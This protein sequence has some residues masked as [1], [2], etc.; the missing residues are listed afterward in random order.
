MILVGSQRGGASA[1]AKHLL[2][3]SDNDHVRVAQLRGF[4]SDDLHAAFNEAHAISKATR[5]TQFLFSLSLNPPME[6]D[7]STEAFMDA[8]ERAEEKLGLTG[9]PRAVVFHEKEGRRH[10]HVVWSRIDADQMKA[11]NLPHFKNRLAGLSKELYLENGWELPRGHREN[12]WKNPMNFTLAEFQQAARY[13]M[14]PREI[15]QVFH[16]AYQQS[17]SQKAFKAALEDAGYY[18]A[19]GDR[20]GMVAIDLQGTVYSVARWSGVKTKQLREK[21]GEPDK[22]PSVTATQDMIRRNLTDK[23]REHMAEMRADQREMRQPYWQERKAL[24]ARQRLERAK[25]KSVQTRRENLESKERAARYRSGIAGVYDLLTGKQRAIRK[26]NEAS[27]LAC[28][29]R[30]GRERDALAF[31]QLK[32]RRILQK[33]IA[34][35]RQDQLSMRKHLKARIA[36]VLNITLEQRAKPERD[37]QHERGRD[38]SIDLSL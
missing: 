9:Q 30:D 25:L 3:D 16:E 31:S 23:M 8:I 18:L 14:D 22:L 29:K 26:E 28:T 20:R 27:V 24:V 21:L 10:A 4:V 32:E 12:G 11:I 2:N 36:Q 17:D 6:A 1:F 15:K 38:R 35:L 5:C 34:G 7:V 37:R 19:R 33:R 13:D